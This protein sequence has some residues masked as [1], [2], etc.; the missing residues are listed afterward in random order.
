M[1]IAVCDDN[2][3]FLQE[4]ERQLKTL[5]LVDNAFLFSNLEAF[6]FSVDGGKRYDAV[7]MD[8]DWDKKATGMDAAAELYKLCPDTK[9]IY[10]TGYV[11][12][13]S[14]HVFLQRANLSGFL[15]KPVDIG[16]LQAN[17]QKVEDAM[18]LQD[19]PALV[20]RRQGAPVSIPMREVYFIESQNHT[21]LVHTA[22]ETITAYELL[23]NIMRSLSVDFYQCHKSFIV[24]MRYIHHFQTSD[25]IL[26]N[27]E[28]VPVSRS[29]YAETKG[30]YLNYM[31]R[32]IN[33][34]EPV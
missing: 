17:L 29:R 24:N 16:L 6:L 26:K 11:E 32:I 4:I 22:D 28:R 34:G 8:I 10:V 9:I 21:V 7:L 19:S 2:K 27:G 30:T 25:I 12:R 31:G 23:E 13:F 5:S 18:H 15:R 14:Q 1:E 3:L 20:L 33:K